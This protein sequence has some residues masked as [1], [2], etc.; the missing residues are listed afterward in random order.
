LTAQYGEFRGAGAEIVSL[1]R[2]TQQNAH[3]YF[4]KHHIPFPCLVDITGNVY[5]QF[6]VKSNLLSFGQRPALFVIDREGI[7]RYAYLG[8]QQWE[9]PTN[10][11]VLKVVRSLNP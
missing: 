3:D 6:E 4:E 2:D 1:V 8:S 5:H 11:E 9:I 7:V 10:E